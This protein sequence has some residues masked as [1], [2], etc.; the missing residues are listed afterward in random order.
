MIHGRPSAHRWRRSV[1]LVCLASTLLA[2][3]STV[4]QVKTLLDRSGSGSEKLPAFVSRGTYDIAYSYGTCT[5]GVTGMTIDE[6]VGSDRTPTRLLQTVAIDS[7]GGLARAAFP[8]ECGWDL[9]GVLADRDDD[10]APDAATDR[11]S[12]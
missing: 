1:M 4:S 10:A 2:C 6:F 8:K 7:S 9:D 11:P 3:Q 12:D 5:G